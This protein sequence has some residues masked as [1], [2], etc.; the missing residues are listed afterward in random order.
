VAL[1]PKRGWD[2]P[3]VDFKTH[4]RYAEEKGLKVNTIHLFF[5]D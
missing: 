5:K 1:Q 4:W 2:A 3:G